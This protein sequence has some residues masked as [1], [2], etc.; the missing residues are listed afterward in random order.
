V[1]KGKRRRVENS[2]L[3]E[4]AYLMHRIV[5]EYGMRAAL[6]GEGNVLNSNGERQKGYPDSRLRWK[7]NI[8]LKQAAAPG[9]CTRPL[10]FAQN[11]AV[12][13]P[14]PVVLQKRESRGDERGGKR[15]QGWKTENL[16]I[17]HMVVIKCFTTTQLRA[18]W[19]VS[20]IVKGAE[21]PARQTRQRTE[22]TTPHF[23]SAATFV[24]HIS[25]VEKASFIEGGLWKKDWEE[26][27]PRK[28][29]RE[30]MQSTTSFGEPFLS[31]SQDA[32]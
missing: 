14:D 5:D 29:R 32:R 7:A 27:S 8:E 10:M 13:G 9:A 1:K 11:L 25:N 15:R 18:L 3:G 28:G 22:E 26:M 6:G 31:I 21:L 20:Y 12:A 2:P 4:N 30:W 19:V 24:R 17:C 23:T 16:K